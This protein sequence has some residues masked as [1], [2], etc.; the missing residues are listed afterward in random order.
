M[1]M[2]V[3]S[4]SGGLQMALETKSRT[5]ALV[6]GKPIALTRSDD[7]WVCRSCNH[8]TSTKRTYSVPDRGPDPI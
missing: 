2:L 5:T 7:K 6:L 4:Q 1:V 8:M 3:I